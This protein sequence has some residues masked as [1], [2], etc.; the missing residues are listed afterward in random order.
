M[1]ISEVRQLVNA[2]IE[3]ARRSAANR[4]AR[5]DEAG[6]EYE[7]FLADTAVPLFR[8]IANVLRARGYVFNVFTPSGSVRLASETAADD[9]IELVLDTSGEEPHVLGRS[10]RARGRRVMSSER[11]I[12]AGPIGGLSES[13]VLDFVLRELEPFVER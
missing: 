7:R 8:Q 9:Y 6:R 11:P 10:S 1:E 13:D 3:R 2:A 12:G 4:R 5:V